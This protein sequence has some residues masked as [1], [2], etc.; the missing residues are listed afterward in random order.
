MSA[1]NRLLFATSPPVLSAALV[2]VLSAIAR[3]PQI[4]PGAVVAF[5][6]NLPWSTYFA[7][8]RPP[9]QRSGVAAHQHTEKINEEKS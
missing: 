5:A 4:W 8:R 7:F 3:A 1:L 2:V 6:L 9:A